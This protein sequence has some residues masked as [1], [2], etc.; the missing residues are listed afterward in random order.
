MSAAIG[1]DLSFKVYNRKLMQPYLIHVQQ[2]SSEVINNIVINI[3]SI[4]RV[5]ERF[6]ALLTSFIIILNLFI[7]LIIFDP[8]VTFTV[9]FSL[10]VCYLS[11]AYFTKNRLISNSKLTTLNQQKQIKLIQETF[12]SIKD[13]FIFNSKDIYLKNYLHIDRKVR[14]CT[15]QNLF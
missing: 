5:V 15:S 14:E 10:L 3:N 9:S 13:I 7:G 6:L 11:L 2:N 12:G 4:V 8:Y 1:N